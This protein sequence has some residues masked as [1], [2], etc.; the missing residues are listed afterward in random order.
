MW[1]D[2]S[3][4]T[5]NESSWYLKHVLVHDLQT[6][7]KSLFICEQWLALDKD[8]F[9]IERILHN[10]SLEDLT[11]FKYLLAKET[12][13]KL[14]NDHLWFSI[15]AKP[16]NSSFT[17]LD[18]L[19]CCFVL[20]TINMVM[21][22]MYYGINTM[23]NE[24]E[25]G[26]RLGTYI[27]LTVEQISVGV[28]T[29]LITIPPTLLLV[30]LFRRTKARTTNLNRLRNVLKEKEKQLP[31]AS[32]SDKKSEYRFSFPWWFKFVAYFISFVFA[33]VSLFFVVVKGIEF[34]EVK[35]T[36]WLTSIM[37][38]FASSVVLMQPLQVNK[39]NLLYLTYITLS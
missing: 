4:K 6:R 17:R 29:N 26:I 39:L 25:N 36:K 20:L 18:R 7:E 11:Q 31:V 5:V 23:T 9:K 30:Q 16:I 24:S 8:D 14:S 28:I 2:N 1:H 12:K 22:I 13:N 15:F 10:S 27:N 38:S 19:T 21:N 3:G 33:S 34:G 35:V 32:Y 37:V